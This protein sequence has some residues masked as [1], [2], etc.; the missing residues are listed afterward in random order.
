MTDVFPAASAAGSV[1]ARQALANLSG[2]KRRTISGAETVIQ[3]ARMKVVE[4]TNGTFTLAFAAAA[5]Y[6][7]KRG[8]RQRYLWTRPVCSGATRDDPHADVE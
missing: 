6:P 7:V 1:D 2:M 5:T 3:I 8:K 4:A